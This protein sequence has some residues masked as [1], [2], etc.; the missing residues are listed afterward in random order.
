MSDED[1]EI[2]SPD[3]DVVLVV[4]LPKPETCRK[5]QV[6]AATLAAISPVFKTLFG[7]HFRE[8]RQTR[9]PTNPVEIPLPDDDSLAVLRLCRM[10]HMNSDDLSTRPTG[11]EL[12]GLAT[13]VDKYCCVAAL[14]LQ[15]SALLQ[16]WCK[17]GSSAHNPQRELWSVASASYLLECPHTFETVTS[18]L[19]TYTWGKFDFVSSDRL[20]SR[21]TATIAERRN[22]AW[23]KIS[24]ILPELSIT[25]SY[26]NYSCPT[27]IGDFMHQLAK[28][29]DLAIW[30]PKFDSKEGALHVLLQTTRH[31][32]KLKHSE[33]GSC[34]QNSRCSVIDKEIFRAAADQVAA[35]C[36][37]LCLACAKAASV[38][39]GAKC[40]KHRSMEHIE[41]IAP[42]GDVILV[43]GTDKVKIRVSSALLANASPVFKAMFSVRFREGQQL[44]EASGPV[45]IALPD[46]ES[47]SVHRLCQMAH[48]RHDG[49]LDN[50]QPGDLYSLAVHI[51]EYGCAD[52]LKFQSAALLLSWL[53][54]SA[55]DRKSVSQDDLW[56]AASASYLMDCAQSFK[57][58]TQR[59]IRDT[60]GTLESRFL[61]RLPAGV[62]VAIAEKRADAWQYFCTGLPDLA[63]HRCDR[64][65]HPPSIQTY[66][67]NLAEACG[68]HHWPPTIN[69]GSCS[70]SYWI[71]KTRELQ[72][73]AIGGV[74]CTHDHYWVTTT[75][76]KADFHDV[77]N[78]MAD[79]CQGLC[80]ECSKKEFPNLHE[81]CT[82]HKA[83]P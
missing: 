63:V 54:A 80:L 79:T 11:V 55:S 21:V 51:D 23:R 47:D 48:L 24:T 69:A 10:A 15:C 72:D 6:S 22:T 35:E 44:R 27:L 26:K 83:R 73:V 46:D 12:L 32:P 42:D 19:V 70:L 49:L 1:V 8:G 14:K 2:V 17:Y 64:G 39:A 18:R 31:L 43:V 50:V 68:S 25:Y 5:I 4:G 45:D 58:A 60:V 56:C 76:T 13:T 67:Q 41:N 20:P 28:L 62:V 77:A 53:E 65:Y 74:G 3:G 82:E 52:S 59:L 34:T 81:A 16:A 29:F 66:L 57:M 36:D 40:D 38:Y 61:S 9:G 33:Y 71:A 78:I 37:G 7:P 30:P 75:V